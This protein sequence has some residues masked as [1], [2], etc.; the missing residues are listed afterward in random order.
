AD[1]PDSH[2]F[3]DGY[4]HGS[5]WIDSA[6][7]LLSLDLPASYRVVFEKWRRMMEAEEG[8]ELTEYFKDR[9]SSDESA[10][11]TRDRILQLAHT[12]ISDKV[13]RAWFN[14]KAQFAPP[15]RECD[16]EF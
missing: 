3:A 12:A 2:Q 14:R 11:Q 15:P 6:V 10:R 9:Y 4:F 7:G 8:S 1:S 13:P 16:F 5:R